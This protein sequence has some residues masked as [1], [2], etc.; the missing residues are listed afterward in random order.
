MPSLDDA[1]AARPGPRV[2]VRASAP[3]EL[4]WALH[5]ALR[6]DF[7]RAH[8]ALEALYDEHPEL[9]QLAATFWDDDASAG[10]GF[11]E[12]LVLASE[13]DELFAVDLARLFAKL[14]ALSARP[15]PHLSLVSETES[16]R[17]VVIDRL[18][19]LRRSPRLRR[20]YRG[21]LEAVWD[22]IG[23]TWQ[24]WGRRA[25]ESVCADKREQLARGAQWP[26]ITRLECDIGDLLPRMVA[27]LEADGELVVIPAYLTHKSL[28]FDLPGLVVVGVRADPSGAESRARTES[29]ARRLKT[30]A[31]PTRLGIV[32]H[33]VQ[34]PS[35]V[36]ELARHFG[37]A[38]P[39]AS[40]HV[41]L[42]RDAGLVV[43]VR[44]GPRRQLTL[45]PATVGD[46]LDHL[47]AML[48]PTVGDT[49]PAHRH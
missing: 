16:D 40:N 48:G 42:L 33:L 23:P 22:A 19:R 43:D 9:L 6:V 13:G 34:G 45:D 1:A 17:R 7:R 18:A 24:Q 39:T 10:L 4:C 29:L 44:T 46:L 14:D 32:D 5:A 11:L 26:E 3:V 20:S 27:G 41:K 31:D 21:L 12:L 28:L 35:T 15:Q 25:V 38:Q 49:T 2:T 8:P 30:L 47:R 37:I 36:S